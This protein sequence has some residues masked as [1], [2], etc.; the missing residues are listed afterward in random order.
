M[1]FSKKNIIIAVVLTAQ[2]AGGVYFALKYMQQKKTIDSLKVALSKKRSKPIEINM[3]ELL[4]K[5]RIFGS[6]N[7]S[8][9]L[10]LFN[11]F[12]CFYCKKMSESI[13][14]LIKK[15]PRKFRFAL[16]HFNRNDNDL[17][18]AQALECATEQG[19]FWPMFQELFSTND[20]NDWEKSGQA[21]N[22][23]VDQ[24]ASCISSGKYREK[25]MNNT[26]LGQTLGVRATPSYVI[27][28]RLYVGYKTAKQ[29]AA[30]MTLD[31][32]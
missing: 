7:A 11:S 6:T 23:K 14:E 17:L 30:L 5:S 26:K 1:L 3:S 2:V 13:A 9:T 16:L 31:K 4:K 12:S 10:V 18:P 15:Y 20:N 32:H 24:L 22:I 27:N 21:I 28:D 8:K 25:T 29:L 19:K